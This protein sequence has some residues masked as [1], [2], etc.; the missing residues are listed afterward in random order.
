MA[1]RCPFRQQDPLTG[2]VY[3]GQAAIDS[4]TSFLT[5]SH[6]HDTCADC[7]VPSMREACTCRW[8]E[9]MTV[10]EPRPDGHHV[11]EVKIYCRNDDVRLDSLG[12]CTAAACKA[13]QPR[14]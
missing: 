11:A 12:E 3:C 13:Y 4:V 1:E 6:G 8:L 14:A 7:P 2:V 10:I 9:L 5:G